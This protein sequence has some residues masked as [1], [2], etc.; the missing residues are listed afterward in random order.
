MS[1]PADLNKLKVTELKQ[2]LAARN[3][4]TKGLKTELVARLTAAMSNTSTPASTPTTQAATPTAP[5]STPAATSVTTGTATQQQA[6]QSVEPKQEAPST[7]SQASLTQGSASQV[8]PTPTEQDGDEEGEEEV[9]ITQMSDAD[10]KRA[11]AE[12]FGIP[13]QQSEVEKKSQRAERFGLPRSGLSQSGLSKSGELKGLAD[14]DKIEARKKRFGA[15]EASST[16]KPGHH[17]SVNVSKAQRLGI[18]VKAD[19]GIAT[20]NGDAKKQARLARFGG[21]LAQSPLTSED[22]E[23]KRKRAERFG[24]GAPSGEAG[25]RLRVDKPLEQQTNV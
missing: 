9:D 13:L 14:T 1:T 19:A 5:V 15:V 11:R 10:R 3:L 21:A 20:S 24:G 23:R 6:P 17:V 25:K 16:K 18:P 12:R 4:D 8:H 2:E 7:P 22:E